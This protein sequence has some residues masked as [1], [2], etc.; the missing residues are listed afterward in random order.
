MIDQSTI[1]RIFS[2][3]QIVEVV[4]D[5][6]GLKK[7][8][9]NYTG[10][11][12]FHNEKTPS[13]S[14]SPGK[15]IFK[16]FGC[17]KAG[18]PVTFIMEHEQL[19]Y[20][21]ALRY[22]AKKYHIEIVEEAP[23][24]D[25]ILKR[26]ERESLMVVAEYSKN[27][28]V[29][30]LKTH[31]EGQAIG[32][33]YLRE[34]GLR[35]D[36]IEK[37]Q[38]GYCAEE[39]D[40]F[41]KEAV[42]NGFKPE[43]LDKV[44]VSKLREDGSLFDRFRGRIIYPIHA[45]AGKVIGFGARVLK[46]DNKEIAKY[47]NSP[48]SEI[49]HKS[50]TLYGIYFAKNSI[51]KQDKCYLVE[52]YM[53]VIAMHQAGIENVV[54]SS[55]TS[56]TID[57]IRMIRRFTQNVTIIYDG[58]PAGIKAAFRGIPMVLEEGLNVRVLLLPDKHD[59]D[60]FVREYSAT[61]LQEYISKNEH[62]FIT[63][64]TGILLDEVKS[65]PA[66][67][68]T[69]ISDIVKTISVI[70]D[71]I[72]RAVYVKECSQLLKVEESMLYAQISLLRKEKTA[73]K[74]NNEVTE[75]K[76]ILLQ[77]VE[78]PVS[79]DHPCSNNERDILRLLVLHGNKVLFSVNEDGFPKNVLVKEYIITEIFDGEMFFVNESNS[80]I[81]NDYVSQTQNGI[82]LDEN[83]YINHQEQVFR[84]FAFTILH[85]HHKLSKLF[86]IDKSLAE[87]GFDFMQEAEK[88]FLEKLVFETLL[89]YKLKRIKIE[90]SKILEEIKNTRE[91]E[92]LKPLLERQMY[93]KEFEKQIAEELKRIT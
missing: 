2:T 4:G 44:G 16:C 14:V 12:P 84:D 17:G 54:A 79:K 57:Q 55:G 83:Y 39:R 87:K 51:I 21:D 8:G 23:S 71:P 70:P 47:L 20:A 69:V 26:S 88:Q 73:S 34:R 24:G 89:S 82:L 80:Q 36:I 49:Y 37:F 67:K 22:L 66:K 3:A 19:S 78:N 25:E 92:N 28:F 56:L 60:S 35:D 15:N 64:S 13:F 91:F 85:S 74:F 53:D 58:D 63:F 72:F 7:R 5:F 75:R 33:T 43:F 77:P 81:F 45:I 65:D 68:A 50:N 76:G 6:V 10:L 30:T 86:M 27:Y 40:S 11:C 31:R 93:F 59:P 9:A 18:S 32:Q 48:E 52:G 62:D 42:A 29:K 61:A 41:S 38:L 1:D 46:T 90:S